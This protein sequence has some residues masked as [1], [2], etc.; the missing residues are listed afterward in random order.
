MK[1]SVNLKYSVTDCRLLNPLF[2]FKNL[3]NVL[4]ILQFFHKISDKNYFDNGKM[5]IGKRNIFCKRLMY[6]AL[7]CNH[8][9]NQLFLIHKV[10]CG[11]FET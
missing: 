6:V 10:H 5:K 2:R 1:S 4:N 9:I 8:E 7:V 11:D 3:K